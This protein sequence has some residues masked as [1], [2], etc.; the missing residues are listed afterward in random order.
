MVRRNGHDIAKPLENIHES[1]VELTERVGKDFI[2]SW[3]QHGDQYTTHLLNVSN[4]VTQIFEPGADPEDNP[5]TLLD[6]PNAIMAG[7]LLHCAKAEG[8]AFS[9]ADSLT[10]NH[11]DDKWTIKPTASAP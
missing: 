1:I 3:H 10:N 4:T 9:L 11:Q 6:E 7:L 2:G 8:K 5:T